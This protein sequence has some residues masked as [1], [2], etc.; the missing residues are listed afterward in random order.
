MTKHYICFD[1]YNL[2]FLFINI[3]SQFKTE[4]CGIGL[5]LVVEIFIIS[6]IKILLKVNFIRVGGQYSYSIKKWF[7]LEFKHLVPLQHGATFIHMFFLMMIF[8]HFCR[9]HFGKRTFYNK[10]NL[11]KNIYQNLF[12]FLF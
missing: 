12:Y 2:N 7:T 6:Q 9:I 3:L 8:H 10:E 11:L 5:L 1:I 4:F